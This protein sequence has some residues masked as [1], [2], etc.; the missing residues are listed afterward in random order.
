MRDTGNHSYTLGYDHQKNSMNRAQI[1]I[2]ES[3]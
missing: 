2:I 3:D 1:K